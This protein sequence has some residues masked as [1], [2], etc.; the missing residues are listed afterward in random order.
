VGTP[1]LR[2]PSSHGG[3]AV[4]HFAKLA[5]IPVV[6]LVLLRMTQIDDRELYCGDTA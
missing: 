1:I 3:F 2:A 4:T 5:T 6:S